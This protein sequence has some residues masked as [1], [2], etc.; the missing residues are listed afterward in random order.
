[1]QFKEIIKNERANADEKQIRLWENKLARLQ[2][3]VD[4]L[5]NAEKK[6][7]EL[8]AEQRAA[9]EAHY[10]MSK[11]LWTEEL[12]QHFANLEKE[13]IGPFCLGSTLLSECRAHG[14]H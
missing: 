1:M 6:E 12:K 9:R 14:F 11:K 2:K 5:A 4:L 8:N 3:N 7:E 13:I 10:A